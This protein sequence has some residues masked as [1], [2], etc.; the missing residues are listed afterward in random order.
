M[1]EAPSTTASAEAGDVELG[2]GAAAPAAAGQASDAAL[3]PVADRRAGEGEQ[4]E[5]AHGSQ[6]PTSLMDAPPPATTYQLWCN[7]G[8]IANGVTFA[9]M[10]IGIIWVLLADHVAARYVL[11]LGLFGWAGAVTNWLAVYMLFEKVPGIYGSG[12]IPGRFKEIRAS[13]KNTIMGTFFDEEYLASYVGS[14]AN[15]LIASTLPA[16]QA[17]LSEAVEGGG[18]DGAIEKGLSDII[19]QGGSLSSMLMMASMTLAPTQPPGAAALVPHMKPLLAGLGSQ[20]LEALATQVDVGTMLDVHALRSELDELMNTKLKL[21]MP[22][23]IKA[24]IREHLGW[25]VVWGAVFGG[26]IGVLSQAHFHC[27]HPFYAPLH[28]MKFMH[29][30][31]LVGVCY[32]EDEAKVLASEIEVEDGPDDDGEMFERP[33]K[34]NDAFPSPYANEEQARSINNGALPPDLSLI[35]KARHDGD[36]YLFALLTGYKEAP[37]GVVVNE[38]AG[39]YYNPYFPGGKI[40]MP[41]QL[42]DGAVEYGDGTPSTISQMA[43]DVT[44][45]LSWAAEPH[46]DERKRAGN[47]FIL[48]VLVAAGVTG[49]YKRMRWAPLKNRKISYRV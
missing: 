28:S 16:L 23:H 44:T 35:T 17:K 31:N 5:L 19:A 40:G 42:V 18:M 30:R 1:A 14:R 27:S 33:G 47:K 4:E 25:L 41:K 10:V 26:L 21:L 36:N 49:W 34:L 3:Q 2:E 13:I 38:E 39:Q 12:V 6:T 15:K 32:T 11:S 20:A 8:N 22:H 45:F 9:I 7:K 24:V 48:F 29:Y 43:K 37:A 46:Q